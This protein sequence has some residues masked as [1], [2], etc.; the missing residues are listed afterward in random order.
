MLKK[1][2]NWVSIP[3]FNCTSDFY[4]RIIED[5]ISDDEE[6]HLHFL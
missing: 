5:Q 3:V 6:Q 2:Y 1:R 4:G